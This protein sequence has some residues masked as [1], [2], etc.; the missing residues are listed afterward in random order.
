M[1]DP[2]V[3]QIGTLASLLFY[4]MRWLEFDI[5]VGRVVLLL[6]TVLATQWLVRLARLRGLAIRIERAQ[7]ADFRAVAV[8]AA[9]HQPR[10]PR[11]ARGGHHNCRQVR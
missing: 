3:Y 4:G 5:S 10:R 8:P 6:A 1:A 9:S 11:G 2:R 7:R